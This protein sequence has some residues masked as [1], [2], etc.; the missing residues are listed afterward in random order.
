MLQS[1]KCFS[2]NPCQSLTE[3]SLISLPAPATWHWEHWVAWIALND[4]SCG[5]TRRVP[6]VYNGGVSCCTQIPTVVTAIHSNPWGSCSSVPNIAPLIWSAAPSDPPSLGE[7]MFNVCNRYWYRNKL[8]SIIDS[9]MLCYD[10]WGYF[11]AH[12]VCRLH[13]LHTLIPAPER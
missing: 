12:P 7:S 8:L 11:Q 6:S 3:L 10:Q 1:Q 5:S 13:V 9:W 4:G 2:R